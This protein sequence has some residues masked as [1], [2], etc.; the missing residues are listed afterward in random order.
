MYSGY[1][2]KVSSVKV[3][4]KS[5]QFVFL[6]K[7][8]AFPSIMTKIFTK[9]SDFLDQLMLASLQ[10]FLY[11][12]TQS[13]SELGKF[14]FPS[15]F[16]TYLYAMYFVRIPYFERH[17][18]CFDECNVMPQQHVLVVTS[19]LFQFYIHNNKCPQDPRVKCANQETDQAHAM[20]ALGV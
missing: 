10:C 8:F 18:F 13:P 7:R 1:H 9:R 17:N 6:V 12:P 4:N 15:W 2:C 20:V 16:N 5:L 3:I 14:N 11:L 19:N